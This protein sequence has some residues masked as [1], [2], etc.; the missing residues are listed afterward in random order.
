MASDARFPAGFSGAPPPRPTRWRATTGTTTGGRGSTRR[1]RRARSRA[2]TRATTTIATATTSGC[3]PRWGSARI[4][5]R[6]S[7]AASSPRTASSRARRSTTTGAC[8]PRVWSTASVRS[9]PSTTSRRRAGWRRRAAGP[10]RRP[11]IASPASASAP[12]RTSA[13]S[14]IGPARSTSPT[15]WRISAIAGDCFR[16]A[17]RDAELHRRAN[18]V[19][20]AAHRKAVDAIKSGPGT[21]SVGLTLAMQDMQAVDG[22]EAFRDAERR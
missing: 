9:S 22:G 13:I 21:A 5:F 2:A 1:G 19:F 11:P 3:W 14:S 17:E 16:P 7:G 8:A 10:S 4:V 6:S 20:I 15:W 18:D 12:R